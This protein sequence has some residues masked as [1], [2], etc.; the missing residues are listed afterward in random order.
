MGRGCCARVARALSTFLFTLVVVPLLSGCASPVTDG[1]PADAT[2]APEASP[3]PTAATPAP[4]TEDASGGWTLSKARALYRQALA[5]DH[6]R[7]GLDARVF[8]EGEE[9]ASY[10]GFFHPS[11]DAAWIRVRLEP[12]AW[13]QAAEDPAGRAFDDAAREGID[14]AFWPNVSVFHGRGLAHVSPREGDGRLLAEMASLPPLQMLR[15]AYPS[16][17]S[18]LRDLAIR[19]VTPTLHEGAP[20]LLL[21]SRLRSGGEASEGAVLLLVDPPRVLHTRFHLSARGDA[22]DGMDVALNLSYGEDAP[23][24]PPEAVMRAAGLAYRRAADG[25]GTWAF[26]VDGGVPLDAVEVVLTARESNATRPEDLPRRAAFRLSEGTADLDGVRVTFEDVDGDGFVSAGDTLRHNGT[27]K[28]LLLL[29]DV[30]TDTHVVPGPAP[31]A[32]LGLALAVGVLARR[33]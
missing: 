33:R 23:A 29:R 20:A 30:Q 4:P 32:L 22:L 28:D 8:H 10:H 1:P 7:V 17:D 18:A 19:N 2:P 26:L 15:A 11:A 13:G 21:G 6:G 9:I 24:A 16:N 12:A 27:E 25:H 14:V 5:T 3:P 31:L